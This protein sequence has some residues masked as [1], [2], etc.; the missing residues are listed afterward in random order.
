MVLKSCGVAMVM[1][2]TTGL[3]GCGDAST[4]AP[5]PAP[6]RGGVV[7]EPDE[8]DAP[9]EL[10][11]VHDATSIPADV[12]EHDVVATPTAASVDSIE[13]ALKA[14]ANNITSGHNDCGL[15]DQISAMN[16]YKGRTTR[17]TGIVATSTT[18]TCVK[19]D[20]F[21]TVGFGALPGKILGITC[22]W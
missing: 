16:L 19:T 10:S 15:A 12:G 9:I 22:Y 3:I 6:D 14:A 21:N 20:G 7:G 2:L 17:S 5:A 8:E 11:A 13:A 1:F 18:V 4:A